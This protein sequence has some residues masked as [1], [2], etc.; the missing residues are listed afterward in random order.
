MNG[1]FFDRNV[2]SRFEFRIRTRSV[3]PF[4][5]RGNKR[6]K[7]RRGRGPLR[8]CPR[9]DGQFFIGGPLDPGT[10]VEPNPG[11]S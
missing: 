3:S 6:E 9:F 7:A 4:R 11:I 8:I 2:F 5:R 10:A 1:V